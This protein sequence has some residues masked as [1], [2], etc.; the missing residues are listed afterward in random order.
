[1]KC[2]G[3]ES[4]EEVAGIN[5]QII[6][7]VR[8]KELKAR[9]DREL[10]NQTVMGREKLCC[11]QILKPHT[12]KKRETKVFIITA[13]KELRIKRVKE[14]DYLMSYCRDC[15][16]RWKLGDYSVQWPL[17][18]FIPPLPPNANLLPE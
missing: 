17:G 14:M 4:D 7:L 8:A 9:E 16:D 15:W 10:L 12:P 3:V 18:A 13:D 2:Y 11:Q 1:M 5:K 6:E